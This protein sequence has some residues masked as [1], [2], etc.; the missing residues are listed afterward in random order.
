MNKL[1]ATIFLIAII[2]LFS[3]LIFIPTPTNS[4]SNNSLAQGTTPTNS[5]SISNNSFQS[6]NDLFVTSKPQGYGIYEER[7]SNV[8]QPGEPLFLY[9]E[10]TGFAY[11]NLQDNLGKP[12]YS[13]SFAASF[14]I[15]D[16]NG[17]NLTGLVLIP[18]PD[19]ISHYKN[20][21]IYIPFT[22]TQSSP[23][24]PGDY[25]IKYT[26]IDRNSGNTFDIVKNITISNANSML[27][28]TTNSTRT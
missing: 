9:I 5:N 22:I 17:K 12:L 10:P 23:F 7:N 14:I 24:P 19:I 21:E 2:G 11:K 3:T 15:Y 1:I 16:K 28:P 4:I 6:G 26:I 27:Q 13:I 18:L 25:T 20:S 8:F